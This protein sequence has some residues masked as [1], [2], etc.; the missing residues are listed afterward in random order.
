M[1]LPETEEGKEKEEGEERKE[2]WRRAE[3]VIAAERFRESD[4]GL[5]PAWNVR[6]AEGVG[7]LVDALV[8]QGLRGNEAIIFIP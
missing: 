2:Q 1:K 6:E 5:E 7:A 4:V 8:I 3:R